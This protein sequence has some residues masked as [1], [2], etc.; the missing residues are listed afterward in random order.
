MGTDCEG[1][2]PPPPPP[3]GLEGVWTGTLGMLGTLEVEGQIEEVRVVQTVTCEEEEAG[4]EGML[5]LPPPPPAPP[6]EG[7]EGTELELSE[8]LGEGDEGTDQ[9]DELGLEEPPPLGL[10]PVPEPEQLSAAICTGR[11]PVWFSSVWM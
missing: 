7:T 10:A 8:G 3:A 4:A 2:L 6:P 11:Q 1:E 5:L 9:L